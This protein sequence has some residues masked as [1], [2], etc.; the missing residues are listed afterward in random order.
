M[1]LRSGK[2]RHGFQAVNKFV[3]KTFRSNLLVIELLESRILLSGD[4]IYSYADPDG[5][6]AWFDT[7]IAQPSLYNLGQEIAAIRAYFA[8][9]NF[10]SSARITAETNT[11]NSRTILL[12]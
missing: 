9:D 7:A 11:T 3:S 4:P 12:T 8:G 6:T 5:V 1:Y 10:F 2:R